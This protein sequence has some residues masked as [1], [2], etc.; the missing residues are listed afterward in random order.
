MLWLYIALLQGIAILLQQGSS[1]WCL[2]GRPGCW[3]ATWGSAL[4]P[5]AA[6]AAHQAGRVIIPAPPP[7]LALPSSLRPSPTLL[8]ASHLHGVRALEEHPPNRPRCAHN[9]P[10]PLSLAP[11]TW[12]MCE[13]EERQMGRRPLC[14]MATRRSLASMPRATSTAMASSKVASA[15]AVAAAVAAGVAMT[16]EAAGGRTRPV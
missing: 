6:P 2:T 12:M 10:A 1:S 14:T 9:S 7:I 4:P 3:R 11:P 15:G 5:P 13:L 8:C 16:H